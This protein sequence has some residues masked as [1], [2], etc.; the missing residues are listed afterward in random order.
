MEI[1][2]LFS[3]LPMKNEGTERLSNLPKV[4]ASSKWWHL[5]LAFLASWGIDEAP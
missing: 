5:D 1:P 3:F 4:I 2:L